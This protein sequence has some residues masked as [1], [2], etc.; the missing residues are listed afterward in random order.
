VVAL[1]PGHTVNPLRVED[2]GAKVPVVSMRLTA[3]IYGEITIQTG[4]VE[5]GNFNDYRMLRMA[6]MPKVDVCSPRAAVL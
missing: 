2:A 1:D 3:T 6:E 4:R 5:Q